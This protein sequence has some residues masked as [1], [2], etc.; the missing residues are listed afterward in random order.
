MAEGRPFYIALNSKEFD[1]LAGI[2]GLVQVHLTPDPYR[3]KEG[4]LLLHFAGQWP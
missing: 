1:T 2:E 4:F 3:P